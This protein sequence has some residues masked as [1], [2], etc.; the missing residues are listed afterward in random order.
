MKPSDRSK[1]EVS[2]TMTKLVL[3]LIMEQRSRLLSRELKTGIHTFPPIAKHLSSQ[4]SS[5]VRNSSKEFQP[6]K[7]LNP[8]SYEVGFS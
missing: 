8:P 1:T 4:F 6:G 2:L 5:Q 3:L 7:P